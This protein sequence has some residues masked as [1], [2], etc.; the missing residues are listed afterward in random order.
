MCEGGRWHQFH[1][2]FWTE[3]DGL[4]GQNIFNSDPYIVEGIADS[5]RFERSIEQKIDVD[6]ILN[7]VS[8]LLS[9]PKQID[10]VKKRLQGDSL[11]E[12]ALQLNYHPANASRNI[13][14]VKGFAQY[15]Y[16]VY[17]AVKKQIESANED[18]AIKDKKLQVLNGNCRGQRKEEIMSENDLDAVFVDEVRTE[19]R[20]LAR[21][22]L[23]KIKAERK[24]ATKPDNANDHLSLADD[25]VN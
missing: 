5:C 11:E 1:Q 25:A 8:A 23:K 16:Q 10:A 4:G 3:P 21:I 2:G 9:S 7:T 6:N 12:I 13:K 20:R 14:K 15:S 22:E 18:K 17:V 24:Q 19:I